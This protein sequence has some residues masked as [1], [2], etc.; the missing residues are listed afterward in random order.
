MCHFR[1]S[2]GKVVAGII[3]LYFFI[4]YFDPSWPLDHLNHLIEI[5]AIWLPAKFDHKIG[6]PFDN[7]LVC[8]FAAK[9]GFGFENGNPLALL[10][11]IVILAV[12]RYL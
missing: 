3:K 8:H 10:L 4:F 7:S 1:Y 11:Y 12:V 9:Y 6:K 2:F 5:Y